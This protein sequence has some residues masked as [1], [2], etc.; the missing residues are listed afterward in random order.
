MKTVKGRLVYLAIMMLPLVLAAIGC[1]SVQK[2][3]L[4]RSEGESA[5][6]MPQKTVLKAEP[7]T[8]DGILLMQA[9]YLIGELP[10]RMPGSENDTPAKVALGK[11]LYFEEAISINKT[12]SCN[13]CHPIDNKG[14]GADNEKT[15]LGALG[16]T[17][18]ATIRRH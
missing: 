13:D 3:P 15:G 1:Q 10:D 4:E 8:P 6:A 7:G 18:R 16:K 12:Q 9:R 2:G 14:A 5:T 17:D 11:K